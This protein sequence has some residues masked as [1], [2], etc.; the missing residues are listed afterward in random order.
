MRKMTKALVSAVAAASLLPLT[1]CG[2]SG[3]SGGSSGASDAK[4]ELNLL[5]PVY[6]DATKGLWQDI[7]KGFHKD[8]PTITVNLEV[9]SWED[10]N[11]VVTTKIQNQQAPDILNID[12]FTSYASDD[13]L[14]PA[15]E[16]VSK[17]TLEKFPKNFRDNASMKGTQY[18]LPLI[19]SARALF[20][21][22]D[23]FAKAGIAAP[24]K[25]WAELEADAKKIKEL[26][27]VD[28]YGMPLG[29]EEA[30]AETAI[31]FFGNGGS[32]GDEKTITIDTPKNVEAA[33]FMKKL[34]D[35]GATQPNPGS[36]QRTPLGQTFFQGKVGMVV[37]LPPYINFIAEKNPSL[38]YGI[39]P[40]PTKDGS[41]MTLG[42]A[43]HIM[44][45]DN[46]D[47]AKKKAIT[48]FLDYFYSDA[49]YEKFVDKEGFIP[50]TKPVLDKLKTKDSIKDFV[51]LIDSAK[52][53][54]FTNP[55]W[56][57]AQGA[58]Q[59]L[60]GKLGQGAKPADLL[61]EIQAKVDAN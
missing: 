25:T 8:N 4:T 48:K 43:D 31:W 42:V 17:E 47:D 21:N 54:P 28:G 35:E 59:S 39:A 57:A 26:G 46:G 19:A 38:N 56:Q 5:V 16:V 27:G 6:S 1:A 30:Q 23:L 61:K 60:I 55:K 49:V 18:G 41:P 9:Q 33:E 32:Y 14:Y 10:I 40:I 12:S 45:F 2:G 29:N 22:K 44:A 15:T 11:T 50:V 20:Y 51:P 7:I 34:I 24:P 58:I 52:F 53:Y 13:L 3:D 37:G 36:S